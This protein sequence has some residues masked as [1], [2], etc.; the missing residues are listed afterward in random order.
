MRYI[1]NTLAGM[2]AAAL[3]TSAVSMNRHRL[4]WL[5]HARQRR[6]MIDMLQRQYVTQLA[7]LHQRAEAE[8]SAFIA[9]QHHALLAI[10]QEKGV[11]EAETENLF[12]RH[13]KRARTLIYDE[14]ASRATIKYVEQLLPLD[15]RLA[16]V[17]N[18]EAQKRFVMARQYAECLRTKGFPVQA[19]MD[20]MSHG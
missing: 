16:D 8:A 20:T 10:A 14:L 4:D 17:K 19:L 6:R 2:V 1:R 9:H 11:T 15:P 18:R 12:T 5:L 3:V 13:Q 7:V